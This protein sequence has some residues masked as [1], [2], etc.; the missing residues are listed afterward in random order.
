MFCAKAGA[1]HVYA[2]DNSNIVKKA[3]EIARVNGL[4]GKITFIQGKAEEVELPVL[5]VDVIISE[6][7]GK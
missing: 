2:V 5:K 4:D 7:M 1:K 6:W 3:R